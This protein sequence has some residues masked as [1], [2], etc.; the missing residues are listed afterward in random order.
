VTRHASNYAIRAFYTSRIQRRRDKVTDGRTV[1]RIKKSVH[2]GV[3]TPHFNGLLTP[4]HPHTR[5][6]HCLDSLKESHKPA[7]SLS[8]NCAWWYVT[9]PR[10]LPSL[11]LLCH[12]VV[13][14]D[15]S[16]LQLSWTQIVLEN[17]VIRLNRF[18]LQE[19]PHI[20]RSFWL[21]YFAFG[22]SYSTDCTAH[23]AIVKNRG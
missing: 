1:Y 5:H 6:C 9:I 14:C 12:S 18:I 21:L 3:F 15:S 19:K 22:F 17:C 8:L 16:Q 7:T 2:V 13:E 11:V 4:L 20:I 10:E 23:I